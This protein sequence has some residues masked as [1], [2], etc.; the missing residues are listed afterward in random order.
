MKKILFLGV[1]TGANIQLRIDQEVNKIDAGLRRSLHRDKFEL[2]TK[3]AVTVTDLRRYLLEE[4]PHI[5]HFS[6]HG[7]GEEGLVFDNGNGQAKLVASDAIAGLF[8]LFSDSIE[9]V[10][11]N[12]CYSTDQADAIIKYIPYVIG[13]N[14]EMADDASTEFSVAFYD[15]LGAGKDIDFAFRLGKS[16]IMMKGLSGNNIPQ[17][18]KKI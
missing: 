17:L 7:Q 14:K 2:I 11:L 16:A 9:C 15:G 13:M 4:S 8:S 1:N 5:I 10:I 18:L 3:L 6:G 12:A